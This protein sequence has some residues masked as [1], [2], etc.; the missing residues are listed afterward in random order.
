MIT[1]ELAVDSFVVYVDRRNRVHHGVVTSLQHD[2]AMVNFGG[3][4]VWLGVELIGV[5]HDIGVFPALFGTVHAPCDHGRWP[6]VDIVADAWTPGVDIV[7]KIVLEWDRR[8]N[9]WVGQC[10]DCGRWYTART[11]ETRGYK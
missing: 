8:C 5:V 11:V 7:S 6:N 10:L 3:I 1:D 2:I 9:R 4:S